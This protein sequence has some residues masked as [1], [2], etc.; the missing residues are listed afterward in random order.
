MTVLHTH[1]TD[2]HSS[3]NPAQTRQAEE[4]NRLPAV[5]WRRAMRL[6][7]CRP[8]V[9]LEGGGPAQVPSGRRT[10]TVTVLP[11]SDDCETRTSEY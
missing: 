8:V 9:D 11:I 2:S 3:T 4:Q 6:Y 10:D 1:T 5:V 7:G